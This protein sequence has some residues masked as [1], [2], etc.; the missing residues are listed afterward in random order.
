VQE[1][2]VTIFNFLAKNMVQM[3]LAEKLAGKHT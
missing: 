1:S 2:L 3:R